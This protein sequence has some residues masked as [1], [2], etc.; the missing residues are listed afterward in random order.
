[1]SLASW[2]EEFYPEPASNFEKYENTT[3]TD[4]EALAHSIKKWEGMRPENLVKHGVELQ[5]A[6]IRVIADDEE[7]H[8]LFLIDSGSCSLCQRHM[9]YGDCNCCP[10]YQLRGI[11]CDRRMGDE[12]LSPYNMMVDYNDV[13][14]M[15]AQLYAAR[16][17]AKEE[18]C[19][20]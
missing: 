4:E 17:K 13:E 11:R 20:S 5:Q 1:M 16:D 19:T 10:L 6:A 9:T 3:R 15:L 7:R 12:S 18:P 8:I 14:P 2:K